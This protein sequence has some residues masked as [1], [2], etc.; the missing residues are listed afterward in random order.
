[1]NVTDHKDGGAGIEGKVFLCQKTKILDW[2]M[3][4]RTFPLLSQIK[5]CL[6]DDIS[7]RIETTGADGELLNQEEIHSGTNIILC[8]RNT[9]FVY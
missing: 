9:L 7:S 8:I 4:K 6:E 5:Y 2:L 1:M 3:Q